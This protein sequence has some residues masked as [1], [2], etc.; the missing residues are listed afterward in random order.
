LAEFTGEH[1]HGK[2]PNVSIEDF[3][4]VKKGEGG[5]A[6]QTIDGITLTQ[7]DEESQENRNY[8]VSPQDGTIFDDGIYTL[9]F[10]KLGYKESYAFVDMLA[11][12]VEFEVSKEKSETRDAIKPNWSIVGPVVAGEDLPAGAQDA[13]YR[14][15]LK[16]TYEDKQSAQASG[17]SVLTIFSMPSIEG[18]TMYLPIWEQDVLKYISFKPTEQ[19]D[20]VFGKVDHPLSE[21]DIEDDLEIYFKLDE[22]IGK[23]SFEFMLFMLDAAPD[24]DGIVYGEKMLEFT[25]SE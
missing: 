2:I 11:D 8:I 10:S 18:I 16:T 3:E 14:L 19:N 25:T 23:D 12:I 7:E 24:W 17:R 13:G 4:L 15:T 1:Q 5:A 21:A 9:K 22:G 6:D 20:V